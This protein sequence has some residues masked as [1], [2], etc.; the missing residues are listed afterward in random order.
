MQNIEFKAELRDLEAARYQCDVLGAQYI[1]RLRQTDTYYKVVDGRLKRREAPGEPTEWIY[2]H[3]PDRVNPKMCNYSIL[4]EDQAQRRWGTK[5]LRAWLTVAK[6]REL[7]MVEEVRIHLD[8]VDRLGRFIEFEAVVSREFDVQACHRAVEELR[9]IF[10][11][12][13]GEPVAPSYSDL[14]AQLLAEE[15][16]GVTE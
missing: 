16:D 12:T 7:W 14:M 11:M 13:M 10:A 15:S 2:Y 8:D 9:R 3:R 1:G 5:R 4:T 6:R